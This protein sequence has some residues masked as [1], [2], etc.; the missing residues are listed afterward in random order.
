MEQLYTNLGVSSTETISTQ[1]N[2]YLGKM[3]F[4]RWLSMGCILFLVLFTGVLHSQTVLISPTGDGGFENGSTFAANG[5][6][7]VN[8]TTDQWSVGSTVALIP[9]DGANCAFVSNNNGVT[10]AYSQVS[11]FNHMYRDITVPAGEGKVTLSFKWRA[12]GE[13]SG[14]TDW[15]NMKIFLGAT[16]IVPTSTTAVTGATQLSGPG[17]VSGMYK[18]NS[19]N[20]NTETITVIVN[21]GT[22]RLFFQWKSDV[23]DIANPPAALD[24]ISVTSVAPLLPDNA[25]INFSATAIT[26]NSMTINWVDNSTNETSFRVYRSTDN[27]NF[28]QIG[29]NINSTS[30]TTT[31]TIYNSPQT[32]LTPGTTYY[33]RIVSVLEGES[34][35]L[36]GNAATLS[37]ATYYWVGADGGTWATL[38]NWNTSAD[39]TGTTPSALANSDVYIIDGA[40]TTPGGALTIAVGANATIGQFKLVDNTTLTLQSTATTTRTFTISGGPGDDLLIE[41][42]S[43]LNLTNTANRIA[44]VFTGMSNTGLIAG[45]YNASGGTSTPNNLNTTGGVGT[46]VRVASTGV[47]TSNINGSTSG[48]VGSAATLIFENGSNWIHQNST[49]VNY[50]PNATWE[51]NATATLAGNITGTTLTSSSTALGNLIVNTTTS[52]AT[53]SAFTFNS[54]LIQGDLTINNTGSGKFRVVT[55]GVVQVNGN[56]NINAGIL[57][58]ASSGGT[59]I[60]KGNVLIAEGA[61][62]DINRGIIQIEGNLVN[63][64]SI[65]SSETTTTTSRINFSNSPNAQTISGSGVFTA[66]VSGIGVSNPLGLT[67][68]APVLTQS[69]NLFSGTITGA[70][71]ITIG[72][73]DALPA[74]VQIGQANNTTPGGSFDSAPV[75]NLGTGTYS[76]L[77]LGETTSRTTGFEIPSTRTITNLLLDNVNGLTIAGGPLEVTNELTLTNGLVNSSLASHIVHGSATTAGTLTGGSATSYINGPI[78]RTINDANANTNFIHFP[79][80]KAGSYNPV[81]LAP[82]TT[83]ASRFLVEAFDTNSGTADM[84]ISN[85]SSTRRWEAIK[86]SGTFTNINVRVGDAAIIN[87]N[88]IAHASTAN[89][90]YNA[91]FG[92]VN[93]FVTGTPNTIQSQVAVNEVDYVG[94]LSYATSNACTGAPAPGNTV[95]SSTAICLGESVA[96]SLQNIVAGTGITYQWYSSPDGVNYNPINLATASTLNVTPNVVTYYQCVVT[97]TNSSQSTTSTPIMVGFSNAILS[98]NPDTICGE[99]EA[100]LAVT[101]S[102]GSTV[103]WYDA[104]TAGNLLG[105][106]LSFTTPTINSTTTYY[107]SAQGSSAGA[108]T[109]GLGASTSSSSGTSFL[110]GFWGGVKTQ[111]IIRAAELSALGLTA[112]PITSLGFEPTTSG[113]T[114]QGFNVLLD[115]TT[116][117]VAPATSSSFLPISGA[118]T[119]YVGT[120]AD[121]GFLPVANT[122]NTLTFGTGNGASPSFNWDGVSNIVV[123]ISWSRVPAAATAIASTMRVDNV[124]FVCTAARQRDNLTPAAMLAET[125][126]G[127]SSSN[128]PRFFINGQLLCDSPRVPVVATVTT[129][130]TFTLSSNVESICNGNSTSLI[131]VTAGAGSYD[132]FVWSPS[133]GVS[134][135]VTNGWIFNPTVTTNYTLTVSQSTGDLCATSVNVLV[136]VNPVPTALVIT[137]SATETC[138]D[139]LVTL[140]ATGGNFDTTLYQQSM[141]STPADFALNNIAGIGSATINSTYFSEGSSSL[142]LTTTSTSANVSYQLNSDL[143]LTGASSASIVFSHIAVMEGSSFSY[144]Y[145]I[146]EYSTDGGNS[147]VLI[148]ASN[149]VGAAN[150]AVFNGNIRFSTRSYP[151]WISTFTTSTSTPGAGPATSLWKSEIINVPAVALNSNQF[152][153]RFRYTTDSSTN[154][155]GWLID[156]VKIIKAVNNVTWTPVTNLYT[157]AAATIPYVANASSA[158]VY[159]KSTTD[160]TVQFT[161]TSTSQAGCFAT[162][163]I[164]IVTNPT[165]SAPTAATQ[166]FCGASTVADLV[167]TGTTLQW[168]DVATGGT[169]LAVNASISTGTYYVTQTLLGCESPRT[170]V[171]VTVNIT[172]APTAANQE[173]CNSAIVANLVATGTALKWYDVSTGGTALAANT[174]LITGTYY[175]SQTLNN[176]EG[177]RTMVEVVVNIPSAPLGDALQTFC[178]TANLSQL[179]INGS[180]IKIYSAATGGTEYPQALWNLIGL[181]DGASYFA[182]QT[183]DGCESLTRFEISVTINPVPTA[184]LASNQSFCGNVNATVANLIA[185]GSNLL[186]YNVATGGTALDNNTTLVSGTY[187]VSQTVGDCE[188]ARTSVTV[189]INDCNIGWGNLQWPP[190]GTINTCG[191]YTVY[192]RVWKSGVTETPGPNSN[193]TAWIGISTTNADPATWDA[194]SW[195]VGTYNVQVGNDDEYMYTFSNLPAGTYYIATRYQFTGGDFWYGGFNSG[196]WNGTSSV[197]SVLTVEEV[198]APTGD[199]VQSI[200]VPLAPDAT[201]ANLVVSGTN[202]TWYATLADAQAGTNALPLTTVLV[203]GNT[204]YAV[205]IV[206]GCRSTALAVTVTV[207]L[208]T[209]IF[210]FAQLRVYPNPVIDRLTITFDHQLQKIEVYN[211]LGQMVRFQEPN[212]TETEVDMTNLPAAT[213]IVRIYSNDAVKEV[214]VIKK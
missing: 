47:V 117:T 83:S 197:S 125:S 95:A 172:P 56:I 46:L 59:V 163:N 48:F 146:I 4:N 149:Y 43:T 99:G 144:D 80:G 208:G 101:A 109:L 70:S 123:T 60:A 26:L 49:T 138:I 156:D 38:S 211:M 195:T 42:G 16:T 118:T 113:Q 22:Y 179:V 133:I 77:Y 114:Y 63:N 32:G 183:I 17:S 198:P 79:V 126:V 65:L 119:V 115:H 148:P 143:D 131:T 182:T 97:C 187:F 34:P 73:G 36:T 116:A 192:G 174:A 53:L 84:S 92:G 171:Q 20:W 164:S 194:S 86:T 147:W 90:V 41:A 37:G 185:T 203:S 5:W 21:P 200:T 173:F 64:G 139:N 169:A 58:V 55:S 213:Y 196:A 205:S 170:L 120:L 82:A 154:F 98:T 88:I 30:S 40:G 184:P 168:Y 45:A 71:N 128:R 186:W 135:D 13:G 158:T 74:T 121:D 76:V 8:P 207:S 178:G 61:T 157:D 190:S 35:F 160:G 201:L 23:S 6:T 206:N 137:P 165:P 150:S 39:G 10:W 107:A 193:I 162:Q 78:I 44:F 103:R 2:S 141:D 191:D 167:A 18:L 202:V 188:S 110:A 3:Q 24:E 145:G 180:N 9:S 175:V 14:T 52:T 142:L 130:P 62:L 214:K 189:T 93:T 106:G 67:I 51:P 102:T 212:F 129:P 29:T 68:S 181:V 87:D 159:Y 54:R 31:G 204:Y 209:N 132:T 11:V 134:G 140:S 57:D 28:T 124:G 161:A 91:P 136:T 7:T 199:A 19:A 105:S 112:G 166:V 15:D 151:D 111:Y 152:R 177:P 100:T 33:F 81:W 176:C 108:V 155:Y 96:L 127:T 12:N 1:T 69:V 153:I 210:D 25:P 104:A 72:T 122:I 89:G 94:Y 27:I 66:R 75:F 85:L 50:I